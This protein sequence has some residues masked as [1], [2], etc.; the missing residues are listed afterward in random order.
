[1]T[2]TTSPTHTPATNAKRR[3]VLLD[4]DTGIDDAL[5]LIYL[6]GAHHAGTIE[7]LGVT[8]SA[9]NTTAAQA[10]SNS[11]HILNLC[12]LPEVPVAA[13]Q[14][15]PAHVELTTTPETHGPTGLGRARAPMWR[16][17][18]PWQHLWRRA[19]ARPGV[20]LIITGPATNAAAYRHDL[21][22]AR[23]TWMGGAF[24]YPGNTTPT[25]EWNAWVDPHGAKELFA[26]PD[27]GLI[28]VCSLGVTSRLRVDDAAAATLAEHAA[29]SHPALA[30]LIR[31]ALGFYLDFHQEQGE[32][33]AAKI[34][35]LA[36]CMIALDA[37]GYRATEATVDVEADSTLLRGT[38]VA[39]TRGMWSRPPNAR[40]VTDV[41]VS[42]AQSLLIDALGHLP[43]GPR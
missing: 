23:L 41:D 3:P 32:G 30:E 38:T 5:A 33:R 25:A 37:V 35:D 9:G 13:G 40:V 12:G 20:E 36:A 8:C 11:R 34:H 28:T 26:R 24:T 31:D 43:A 6:A 1:M 2:S 19:L 39:D 16:G 10:A 4:C 22:G 7:L 17:V 29:A 15:G 42:G 18:E 14:P 27:V 21:N